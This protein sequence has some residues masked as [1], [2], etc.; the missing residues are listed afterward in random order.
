MP[1]DCWPGR[2]VSAK[3]KKSGT[4]GI[5]NTASRNKK[6]AKLGITLQNREGA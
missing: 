1:A 3:F 4:V 6:Y 5:V 2:A